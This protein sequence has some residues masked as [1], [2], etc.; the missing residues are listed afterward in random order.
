LEA[1]STMARGPPTSWIERLLD[2][3]IDRAVEL[4]DAAY[5]QLLFR[6]V[7]VA[8][9]YDLMQARDQY[10]LFTQR[11][12]QPAN[13]DLL[14]K[15]IRTCTILLAP[16]ISHTSEFI[17]RK[18]LGEK[19]SIF[20]N[21]NWPLPSKNKGDDISILL[22]QNTYLNKCMGVFRGKLKEYTQPKKKKGEEQK[23]LP[24]PTSARMYFASKYPA[25][26]EQA[27]VL[28]KRAY[29]LNV[30]SYPDHREISSLVRAAGGVLE[31]N[32]KKVM[33]LVLTLKENIK[34]DGED[35]AFS[36]GLPFNEKD[37]I[38]DNCLQY[39]LGDLNI[40][41]I[42][43]YSTTDEGVPETPQML[44]FGLPGKPLIFFSRKTD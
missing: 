10:R 30:N 36:L 18:L 41:T 17:W 32:F 2:A 20:Q 7:T 19:G 11:T 9:F 5:Q 24:P 43:L 26:Q 16:I 34:N 1:A 35:D 38:N 29:Q 39:I 25:W 6:E 4:C 31:Q 14:V 33:P 21:S 44:S 23:V 22:Q 42:Q 28:L 8:G 3:Q 12:G 15:F 37:F 27:L 13:A 40:Q